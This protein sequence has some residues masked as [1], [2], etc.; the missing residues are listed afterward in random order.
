MPR[1]AAGGRAPRPRLYQLAESAPRA[2]RP[3]Y[4]PHPHSVGDSHARLLTARWILGAL[5]RHD[6][7]WSK[8]MSLPRYFV[9][10]EGEATPVPLAGVVAHVLDTFAIVGPHLRRE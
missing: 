6:I 10:S 5:R 8:R 3:L 1:S 7:Y 4:L 9:A 2:A